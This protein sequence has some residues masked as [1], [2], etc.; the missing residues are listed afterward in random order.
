MP[1]LSLSTYQHL[2]KCLRLSLPYRLPHVERLPGAHSDVRRVALPLAHTFNDFVR[3]QV[4][5]TILAFLPPILGGRLWTTVATWSLMIPA[6][7]GS[8]PPPPI[9]CTNRPAISR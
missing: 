5:K 6:V 2:V 8:K 3:N 1:R 7:D 4:A 9:P